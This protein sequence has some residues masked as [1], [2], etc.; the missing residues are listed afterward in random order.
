MNRITLSY[1]FTHQIHKRIQ[2]SVKNVRWNFLRR[3][4]AFW[5]V[6]FAKNYF[7]EVLNTPLKLFHSFIEKRVQIGNSHS[8]SAD[9]LVTRKGKHHKFHKTVFQIKIAN[10]QKTYFLVTFILAP[11]PV[12]RCEIRSGYG[13]I[14][15]KT[16]ERS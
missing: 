12:N 10:S 8:I 7:S 14:P 1:Y 2:N 15:K 11:I 3:V 5:I 6:I 16:C 13:L 9:K 4:K